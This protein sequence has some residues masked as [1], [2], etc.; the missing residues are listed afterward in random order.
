M[1][2]IG[3]RKGFFE[4]FNFVSLSHHGHQQASHAFHCG[5]S[6]LMRLGPILVQV[7][8]ILVGQGERP[9]PGEAVHVVS[10]PGMMVLIGGGKKP[11]D[12]IL[13]ISF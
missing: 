7:G 1:N 9:H 11:G 12:W 3:W 4:L 8:G 5:L 2:G 6:E 13:Q 10:D